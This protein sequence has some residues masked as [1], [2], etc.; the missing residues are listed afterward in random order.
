MKRESKKT[1]RH[2]QSKPT[3]LIRIV[4]KTC[5][6]SGIPILIELISMAAWLAVSPTRNIH[7]AAATLG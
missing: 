1:D 6:K 3:C 5:D 2:R 4:T 7:L